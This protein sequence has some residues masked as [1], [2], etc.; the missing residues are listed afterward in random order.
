[1]CDVVCVLR[2]AENWVRFIG[3]VTTQ[4]CNK[5]VC[6]RFSGCCGRTRVVKIS[7]KVAA[8]RRRLRLSGSA[9]I[10]SLFCPAMSPEWCP[11]RQQQCL[12]ADD[13]Q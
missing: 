6:G 3:H 7:H 2:D 13:L 10:D 9:H 4:C 1:M 5:K 8:A 11:P 12:L